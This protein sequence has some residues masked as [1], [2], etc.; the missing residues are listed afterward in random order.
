MKDNATLREASFQLQYEI[1]MLFETAHKLEDCEDVVLY[2]AL[3]ESFLIHARSLIFFFYE[4]PFRED[5]IVAGHF[6]EGWSQM[7][8]FRSPL[9]RKA[10]EE[11]NKKVT[12]LTYR[13]LND[14]YSWDLEAIT[15]EIR[16]VLLQFCQA[17][18]D[19]KVTDNFKSYA[20]SIASGGVE[21]P[22]HMPDADSDEYHKEE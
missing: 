12:H 3:L 20:V 8:A 10:G 13:R 11:A 22:P 9:L 1:G 18:D 16:A 19:D 2:N 7:R 17:V 14:T 5:D 21:L 4:E 6:V 15:G